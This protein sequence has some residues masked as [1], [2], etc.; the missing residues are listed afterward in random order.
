[1]SAYANFFFYL[2]KKIDEVYKISNIKFFI[3]ENCAN[4]F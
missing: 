2:Y 3:L 4:L 1:M